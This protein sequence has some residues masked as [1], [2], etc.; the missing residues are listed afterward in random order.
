MSLHAILQD[1]R[2]CIGCRACEIHCKTEHD[3]PPGPKFCEI[4]EVG[5]EMVDGHPRISFVFMPCYH[6]ETAW[7]ITACPTGAMRRRDEDGLVFV[8]DR[9]CVGCKACILSCP[10]GVPQWDATRGKVFKCDHCRERID[11][12][13]EPA[14]VTGCTTKAL[15]WV[16]P[17]EISDRRRRRRA[18]DFAPT[19]GE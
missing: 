8:E 12:G 18:P 4:V 16:R 15:S 5:P 3:L 11:E 9:L 13:L 14:C 6:C 2:R 7:C 10:W 17:D 1:Q 19:P